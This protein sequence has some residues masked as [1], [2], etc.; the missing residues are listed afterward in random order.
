M[1]TNQKQLNYFGK[2]KKPTKN[3]EKPWNYHEITLKPTKVH[4]NHETTLKN[5]G[6][7]PK[8]M[9]LPSKTL[10]NKTENHENHKNHETT[11]KN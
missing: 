7:K 11:L 3:H 5:Y 10:G 8:T 2:P 1:K 4:K 6:N 9:K